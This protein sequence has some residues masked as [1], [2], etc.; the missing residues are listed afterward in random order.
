M[1]VS[2]TDSLDEVDDE[3]TVD[4]SLPAHPR[5]LRLAR[6][7]AS[8]FATE[9]D[10]SIDEI[11][12]LRLAVDE[13]CAVLMAHASPSDRLNLSYRCLD[14]VMRID[15]RCTNGSGA[16]VELDA[17]ARAILD[18]AV[19]AYELSE[20]EGVLAFVLQKRGKPPPT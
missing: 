17:V 6:L 18:A 1:A 7:T 20:S 12:D 16:E 4:L 19:D 10:F 11:E 8:G 14:G 5:N 3:E 15:G 13:A 2:D 9:L